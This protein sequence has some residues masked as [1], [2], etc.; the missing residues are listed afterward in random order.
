MR[1]RLMESSGITVP[2]IIFAAVR[3]FEQVGGI[4]G[5]PAAITTDPS[6]RASAEGLAGEASSGAA[7]RGEA[8]RLPVV[9]CMSLELFLD[10]VAMPSYLRF[11]A[12]ALLLRTWSTLRFDDCL[13]MDP[14]EVRDYPE[15]W[16]LMLDRTKTTGPGRRRVQV[17]AYVSKRAFFIVPGWMTTFLDLLKT[18]PFDYQRDYLVPLPGPSSWGRRPW[19]TGATCW[20]LSVR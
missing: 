14:S 18:P 10:D 1:A 9:I 5:A 4:V 7:A 16:S 13:G 15:F 3:M 20:P 17:K 2:S 11:A 19:R 8:K 6:V 12:G